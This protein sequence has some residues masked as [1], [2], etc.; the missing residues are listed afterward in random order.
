MIKVQYIDEVYY[1]EINER[2]TVYNSFNTS[3][4]STSSDSSDSIDNSYNSNTYS[5]SKRV[6]REIDDYSISSTD[7]AFTDKYYLIDKKYRDIIECKI[8]NQQFTQ[9]EIADYLGISRKTLYQRY[10]E[11]QAKHPNLIYFTHLYKRTTR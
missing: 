3:S 9:T 10:F 8:I 7:K 6:K 1:G 11:I 2:N 4:S 5:S